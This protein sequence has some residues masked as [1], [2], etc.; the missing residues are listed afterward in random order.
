MIDIHTHILPDC[1][2]GSPDL[3][4]SVK[5]LK[6]IQD[7]GVS[8]VVLT[9]HFLRNLYHNSADIIENRFDLLQ[10][11]VLKE[12][13]K[14]NLHKA[15]EVY[16]DGKIIDD[17]EKENLFI[18][19]TKYIL[20]ETSMTI[21]PD[22][23]LETLYHLVRKGYRPIMAHPERYNNIIRNIGI[24]E[25]LMFRNVYLQ[26]NAGSIL[27]NNGKQVQDTAWQMLENGFVH[28]LASDNHCRSDEYTLP[29]AITEIN[30][31]FDESLTTLL[32]EINPRKMLNNEK[33]DIFYM[34]K[35]E[36]NYPEELNFFE[37]VLKKIFK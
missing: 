21:F 26:L 15:A 18:R 31:E 32:T 17:I 24:A 16:L 4:T 25:D 33:I 13:L 29:A 30:E 28:F 35:Q 10:K 9:P 8:D 7:A 36:R 6:I 2:D 27:G 23:L 12:N 3:Q 14:I 5:K 20:V 11:A 37:K 22:D 19:D 1:D 34:E